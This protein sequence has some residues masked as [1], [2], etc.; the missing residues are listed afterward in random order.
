VQSKNKPKMTESE[1][2]HVIAVKLLCCGV[3]SE[4]GGEAAPSEA[5]ELE[6]GQWFTS[7]PL[8]GDCHRGSYNGLHGEMRIWKVMKLEPLDVLNE[9]IRK[10]FYQR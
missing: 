6:Q 8:C 10:L 5:H 4:G 7:I 3:C 1:R 9:T 2:R